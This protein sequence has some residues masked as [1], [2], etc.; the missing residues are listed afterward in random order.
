MPLCWHICRIS[1]KI[2]SFKLYCL[3]LTPFFWN[4]LLLTQGDSGRLYLYVL[5]SRS[6]RA[7]RSLH[8]LLFLARR[9]TSSTENRRPISGTCPVDPL[10]PLS[11]SEP[12]YTLD[13]IVCPDSQCLLHLPP[14]WPAYL[15]AWYLQ[16]PPHLQGHPGLGLGLGSDTWLLFLRPNNSDAHSLSP[17]SVTDLP[18]A[19]DQPDL[20]PMPL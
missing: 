1:R 5:Q 19:L 11:L 10:L 13:L 20:G 8:L 3:N 9:Q 6:S 7:H 4:T 12:L 15:G 17:A 16:A 2:P 14:L 18:L